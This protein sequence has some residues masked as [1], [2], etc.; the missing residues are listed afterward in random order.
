V[1]KTGYYMQDPPRLSRQW[2]LENA[3]TLFWVALVS[4]LIWIYADIEFTDNMEMRATIQLGIGNSETLSLVSDPNLEVV[5]SLRGSQT[6]L[7][8]FRRELAERRRIIRYDVSQR[9]GV[10]EHTVPLAEI[11]NQASDLQRQGISVQETRPKLVTFR[12]EAQESRLIPVRLEKEGAQVVDTRITPDRVEVS[13][14]SSQW[15]RIDEQF[16]PATQV[17][18]TQEVNLADA[19]EGE[20]LRREVALEPFAGGLMPT[21]SRVSVELRVYR[22]TERKALNVTIR[23]VTPYKWANDDTWDKFEL[24]TRE[25]WT[26][27]L[28][29]IGPQTD[30]ENLSA[31]DVDAYIELYDS[32]KNPPESWTARTIKVHLPRGLNVRLAP[33]QEKMTLDFRL[34]PIEGPVLTP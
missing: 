15:Q 4:V 32:D 21:P 2:W 33:D 20:I 18:R 31:E 30:L 34:D 9:F 16:P 27:K 23:I 22:T 6:Q 7:E 12:V 5:F 10:G 29:F 11:L 25:G 24:R 28:E 3:R 26:K 17:V 19:Q 13:A 1:S 14:P 8:D